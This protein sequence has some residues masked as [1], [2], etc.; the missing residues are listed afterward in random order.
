MDL[1]EYIIEANREAIRSRN[2]L[3]KS[4][5]FFL[6][7][8]VE[9]NEVQRDWL[10]SRGYIALAIFSKR[11]LLFEDA[12]KY[13]EIASEMIAKHP[14]T[15]ENSKLHL[16]NSLSCKAMGAKIKKQFGEASVYLQKASKIFYQIDKPKEAL[17]CLAKMLEYQA[18]EFELIED[19]LKAS[20]LV[21]EAF[22]RVNKTNERLGK[23]YAAYSIRLRGE[24]FQKQE[25][26]KNA[27]TAYQEAAKG[28]TEIGNVDS[29]S[30]CRGNAFFCEA[31]LLKDSPEH[32]YSKIAQAFK[33][34]A[35]NYREIPS[36]MEMSYICRGDYFK[37]L[38][39]AARIRGD[40]K[41]AE[42]LF[43][44][45]KTI[46]FGIMKR[47]PSERQRQFVRSG[48]LWCEGM[49]TASKAEEILLRNISAKRRMN[50]VLG[51]LATSSSKLS[52]SG[53][54]KLAKTIS[55]LSHFALAIDAFHQGDI[56]KATS[57]VKEAKSY[58]PEIFLHSV[59][60][61]EIH[62]G[63][64]PLRYA[65]EMLESFNK[66]TLRIEKEKGYSFESRAR[67]LLRKMY[68][69]FDSI[70]EKTFNPKDD[71]IGIVFDDK[72][73]IEIDALGEKKGENRLLL[74]IGETKNLSQEVSYAEAIKFLKKIKFVEK[75][76]GKIADLQSLK[77]P[78]VIKTVFISRSPLK[79][80]ARDVL[81]KNSVTV[82]E[83]D[84]STNYSKISTSSITSKK[85]MM[86]LYIGSCVKSG[87]TSLVLRNC[88]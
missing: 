57:F 12:A 49:A 81:V 66:Y 69:E 77:K 31:L 70:E 72:T 61:S 52:K 29:A 54:Y 38:G 75:R 50:E 4:A 11:K 48:V 37:N 45:A 16:A 25:D 34:A 15:Q 85:M 76:Y 67:D 60:E 7:G 42:E 68:Q 30:V 39:L 59:L 23:T 73:P 79:A 14:G 82:F 19:Y 87:V 71:E 64:E 78:E 44:Q 65:L 33:Q 62:S 47:T 43:T 27:I 8:Q 74:L 1:K 13:Y 35:D 5:F 40:R 6:S 46:F 3:A 41:E 36:F 2:E 56:P 55:G 20:T 51:L 84:Q 28:Y 10:F 80:N 86:F 63:W 32:D 18:K 58:I 21:T 53:D 24:H 88:M 83:T 17:F 26:Y 9:T 22:E